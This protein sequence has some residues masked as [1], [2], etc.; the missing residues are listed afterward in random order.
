MYKAGLLIFYFLKHVGIKAHVSFEWVSENGLIFLISN[1]RL[2]AYF[3]ILFRLVIQ[4]RYYSF[5]GKDRIVIF[6]SAFYHYAN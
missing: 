5:F 1:L 6:G 4:F 2:N 3:S